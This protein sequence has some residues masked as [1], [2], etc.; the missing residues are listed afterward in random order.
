MRAAWTG[1]AE[2]G[3]MRRAGATADAGHLARSGCSRVGGV[4]R[5]CGGRLH[6]RRVLAGCQHCEDTVHSGF[7]CTPARR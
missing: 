4:T 3:G 2:C 7:A 5:A 6:K 1:L